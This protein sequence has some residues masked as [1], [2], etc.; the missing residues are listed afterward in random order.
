MRGEGEELV[1][2]RVGAVR[3]DLHDW[4]DASKLLVDQI[5]EGKLI[6]RNFFAVLAI[7]LFVWRARE[8]NNVALLFGK[9]GLHVD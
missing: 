2:G 4:A 6:L 1:I 9:M 7:H 5:G 8:E 3:L